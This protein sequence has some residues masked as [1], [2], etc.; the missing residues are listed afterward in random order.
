M[1]AQ[2][3]SSC[4]NTTTNDS[5]SCYL[6]EGMSSAASVGTPHIPPVRS[7]SVGGTSEYSSKHSMFQGEVK[8]GV[9]RATVRDVYPGEH[10]AFEVHDGEDAEETD[11]QRVVSKDFNGRGGISLVLEMRNGERYPEDVDDSD[12]VHRYV[13]HKG[14]PVVSED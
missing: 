2:K 5:G 1:A 10:I 4:N 7:S 13:D 9:E 8:P 14:E 12:Y 6:H 11:W 3:C